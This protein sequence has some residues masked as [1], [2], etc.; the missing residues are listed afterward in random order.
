MS[1]PRVAGKVG[2]FVVIGIVLIGALMLNFSRGVGLF[3]PKYE[4]KMRMRTV[5][6][7]KTRSA[8]L[9]SGIQ[10]G[11]V[12]S[13]ELDENT[14][15]VIVRLKILKQFPMHKDAVFMIKQIGVLGDQFVTISPGS[16][17]TPLLKN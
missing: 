15:D 6:G 4:I 10:I 14:K 2:L 8:V 13:V 5:A 11:N 17:E 7:L 1:Q 3:K 16:A 12:D 9:L